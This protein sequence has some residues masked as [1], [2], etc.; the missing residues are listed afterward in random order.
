MSCYPPQRKPMSPIDKLCKLYQEKRLQPMHGP[1]SQDLL[2][3]YDAGGIRGDS[4][5]L[6]VAIANEYPDYDLSELE[7]LNGTLMPFQ[8]RGIQRMLEILE[9]KHGLFLAD[10]MGLGKT[11]QAISM[12][13]LLD[14][15]PVLVVCPSAVKYNW[16]KEFRKWIPYEIKITVLEGKTET[17]DFYDSHVVICNYDILRARQQ[18]IN[19]LQPRALI[20]DEFHKIKNSKSQ[21]SKAVR[22]I[23]FDMDE[24]APKLLLT[25]TPILNRPDE[26]WHPLRVIDGQEYIAAGWHEYVTTY[27]GAYRD[28]FGWKTGGATRTH[29][30][31]YKLMDSVMVR[32]KKDEVLTELPDLTESTIPLE[33]DNW[34][35]YVK[36]ENDIISWLGQKAASDTK[37]L[38]SI[39]HLPQ[40]DQDQLIRARRA[41]K[42]ASAQRAE[43][44]VRIGELKQIAAE[45]KIKQIIEW[46]K[47]F[48]DTDK[49]LVV[50]ANHKAIQLQLLEELQKITGVA[51]IF[52]EDSA[53]I[54]QDAVDDFQTNPETRVMVASLKAAAEGITLTAASDVVFCELGWS[55]GEHDQ[56]AAR[57]HRIG[58]DANKVTAY[59]F[60]GLNTIEELIAELLDEKRTVVKAVHD[61]EELQE[62]E[63]IMARLIT[64][65]K[66][67]GDKNVPT[68]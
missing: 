65:L 31:H 52:G 14:T 33:I 55:P 36:A 18:E 66:Q 47:D 24:G 50:F 11:I 27:C 12:I 57:V 41:S 42:E 46:I 17:N 34:S 25:G 60:V 15:V 37:F 9:T 63:S 26:L 44:L 19:R 30:L 54:R 67:K 48:L 29:E 32:R 62:Q 58:Q 61:G 68:R 21:R 6:V 35:K 49:K 1:I 5:D 43:H 23:A 7:K 10:D 8:I 53:R 2:A 38:Q 45:G 13:Y 3:E 39:A 56:A 20:V 4:W 51:R 64:H 16:E 40:E 59:Y 28:R 22:E